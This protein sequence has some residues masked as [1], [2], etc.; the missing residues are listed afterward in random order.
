MRTGQALVLNKHFFPVG[1]SSYQNVL[2]NI[3]SGTQSA[4]DITY[5]KKEDGSIDFE[6]IEFWSVVSDLHEWMTLPIRTFDNSFGTVSGPIRLPSVVVCNFYKDIRNAQVKFPTKRNIW[7]RDDNTCVYT[8]RRLKE[9]ELSVDHVIPKSKGGDST[10]ENLVTCDRL[11]NSQ[12]GSKSLKE[13]RLKL[14]YKP[15]RP[16]DNIFKF[17]VYKDEWF[18]FVA[19]L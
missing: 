7:E 1:V 6:N 3:A 19:N 18:S 16:V 11:L 15:F 13:A 17:K 10:W 14:R 4:L 8:G 2:G 12:K 5:G 9:K